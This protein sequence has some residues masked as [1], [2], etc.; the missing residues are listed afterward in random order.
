LRH[1]QHE[2]RWGGSDDTAAPLRAAAA[3]ALMRLKPRDLLYLLG[4]LLADAEKAARS[5]AAKAL[6]ACGAPGALALLRFKA[7]VGDAEPEVVV[8]CLTALV[9][10]EPAESIPFVAEFLESP[11]EEIASGAALA[12]AESRLPQA[13][14]ILKGRWPKSRSESLREVLLLAIAI[15]RLPAALEYLLEILAG[16]D[17]SAAAAALSAL[18]IHRHNPAVRDHIAAIIANRGVTE[19]SDRFAKEFGPAP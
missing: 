18:A 17:A 11:S 8:D 5:G 6:G 7:R 1:V 14:D 4:D 12:L 13:L 2:P 15:T 10:A 3:F 9:T 16:P 19:L